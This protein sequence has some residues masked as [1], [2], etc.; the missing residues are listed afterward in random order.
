MIVPGARELAVIPEESEA[1]LLLHEITGSVLSGPS[2][3]GDQLEELVAGEPTL[4]LNERDDKVW[5]NVNF[6]MVILFQF[7]FK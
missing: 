6:E 7:N 4:P 1:D 5:D 3:G 2:A